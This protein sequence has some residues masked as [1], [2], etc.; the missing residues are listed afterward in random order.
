MQQCRWLAI[1]AVL[2]WFAIELPV[3]QRWLLTT[4]STGSP[5]MAVVGMALLS[6]IAADLDKAWRRR[7]TAAGD[8]QGKTRGTTLNSSIEGGT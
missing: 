5:W 6:S 7:R 2:T 8:A 3:L 4:R 1:S